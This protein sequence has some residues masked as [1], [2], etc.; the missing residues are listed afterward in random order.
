MPNLH[1]HVGDTVD[2]RAGYRFPGTIVAAF[3]TLAGMERYV[4]EMDVFG[5]LHIFNEDQLV[6]RSARDRGIVNAV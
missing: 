5:L 3:E 4:V 6:F 2:K 1:F